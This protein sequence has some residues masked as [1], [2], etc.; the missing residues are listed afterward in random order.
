MAIETWS[1]TTFPRLPRARAETGPGRPRSSKKTTFPWPWPRD[2][3]SCPSSAVSRVNPTAAVLPQLPVDQGVKK[4]N[5]PT[6]LLNCSRYAW[7]VVVLVWTVAV[8]LP[9][10]VE[11]G[12]RRFLFGCP[13]RRAVIRMFTRRPIGSRFAA[14]AVWFWRASTT[15]ALSR[16][17]GIA[18]HTVAQA[19]TVLSSYWSCRFT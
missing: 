3:D 18:P 8:S 13:A 16:P 14:T 7:Q 10:C 5:S 4:G 6:R 12:R 17:R 15:A 2:A 11:H 9:H 19:V 1:E